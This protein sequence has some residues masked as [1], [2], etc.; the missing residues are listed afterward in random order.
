MIVVIVGTGLFRLLNLSDSVWRQYGFK[1]ADQY[2]FLSVCWISSERLIAGT[3][4]GRIILVD[5]GELK[6]IYR[7]HDTDTIM[8]ASNKEQL[9]AMMMNNSSAKASTQKE[10]A[11]VIRFRDGFA[12]TISPNIV[13][14]FEKESSDKYVKKN[15]FITNSDQIKN[16]LKEDLDKIFSLSIS[17][18]DKR[19]LCC[20]CRAQ[21][22]FVNLSNKGTPDKDK[23]QFTPLI[24][25][26]HYGEVKTLS[27]CPWKPLIMTSGMIDRRVCLFNYETNKLL[28]SQVFN[29][30]IHS[31][32]L[33]PTGL[34][35]IISFTD[36]CHVAYIMMGRL[37]LGKK[38]SCEGNSE[39]YSPL[40]SCKVMEF[41]LYGTILAVAD[42]VHIKLYDYIQFN[43]MFSLLGHRI[44]ITSFKWISKD[45]ILLSCGLDGAVYVWDAKHGKRLADIVTRNCRY[46]DIE[47]TSDGNLIYTVGEDGHLKEIKNEAVIQDLE[48]TSCSL[49]C[50]VMSKNDHIVVISN[51]RGLVMVV[52]Y[53]IVQKVDF[54]QYCVHTT[55]VTLMKMTY[56][57]NSLVTCDKNG[58]VCFW[59]ISNA[60]GVELPPP[61]NIYRCPDIFISEDELLEKTN[62]II[63]LKARLNEIEFEHKIKLKNLHKSHEDKLNKLKS[64][65]DHT[66][67][68]LNEKISFIKKENEKNILS[69]QLEKK[70]MSENFEKELEAVEKH[71]KY[72]LYIRECEKNQILEEEI[73][74]TL[75]THNEQVL[76]L[77]NK[78]KQE[79]DEQRNEKDT[80][81]SVLHNKIKN[82]QE[83]V[84]KEVENQDRMKELVEEDADRTIL[85]IQQIYEGLIQEENS[86]H[87]NLKHHVGVCKE[88]IKA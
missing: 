64:E 42:G 76:A 71:L 47:A 17:P 25:S 29:N 65:K 82:L 52:N 26:L 60:D 1:K 73:G 38:I 15:E 36:A 45:N 16:V 49:T 88:E 23:I 84:R 5:S 2:N 68:M 8:F 6:A 50:I 11:S 72:N 56:E 61:K 19:M 10:V 27:I 74:K 78:H 53:P 40:R 57:N 79:F 34:F 67:L 58:M 33:H 51:Q 69:L 39:D 83:T 86:K 48:V 37:E 4:D 12:F 13:I 81:F 9:Q 63:D 77:K 80:E 41:S 35:C 44:E 66:T 85:E 22:Y 7:A 55:A 54:D 31:L 21:I 62:T 59:V 24:E 32:V 75:K 87:T 20:T 30:D 70:E 28:F 3:S 14:L 43:L 46:Q 18:D